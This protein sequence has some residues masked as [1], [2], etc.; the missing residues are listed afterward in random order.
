MQE[1]TEGKRESEQRTILY[2]YDSLKTR[3]T[4]QKSRR[5]KERCRDSGAPAD[6]PC[7]F[8][9]EA[10]ER[11]EHRVRFR[12]ANTNTESTMQNP[13]TVLREKWSQSQGVGRGP[14]GLSNIRNVT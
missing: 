1:G 4:E 11:P 12:P 5:H 14:R 3:Q 9:P 7:F 2:F 6:A 13:N 8:L 10:K